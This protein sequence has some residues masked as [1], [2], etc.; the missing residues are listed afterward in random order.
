MDWLFNLKRFNN[1]LFSLIWTRDIQAEALRVCRRNNPRWPGDAIERRL[2]MLEDVMDEM[3]A[4]PDGDYSFS[5]ADPDDFHVHAAAVY[6]RATYILSNNDPAHLTQN[7]DAEHYE[8]VNADNFFNLVASSN[9]AAFRAAT[10][11]QH[12]YWSKLSAY[13]LQNAL[14]NAGCPGF[15][16][17]VKDELDRLG[18]PDTTGAGPTAPGTGPTTP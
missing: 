7:P 14:V 10:R 3:V 12:A 4:F 5:G 2:R 8:V 15:A 9:L 1:G 16:R 17:R 11:A 6:T 13:P 18:Y